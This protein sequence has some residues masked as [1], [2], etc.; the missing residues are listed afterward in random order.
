[1]KVENLRFRIIFGQKCETFLPDLASIAAVEKSNAILIS[2]LLVI[3]GFLLY[4]LR[5]FFF[6]SQGLSNFLLMWLVMDIFIFCPWYPVISFYCETQS[7][8]SDHAAAYPYKI[9]FLSFPFWRTCPVW[10]LFSWTKPLFSHLFSFCL[11][12]HS[13]GTQNYFHFR[14]YFWLPSILSCAISFS[15]SGILIMF[16]VCSILFYFRRYQ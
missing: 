13:F 3:S 8:G 1:M 12:V 5:F 7:F 9:I 2:L 16:Q 14:N 15:F 10:C 4:T 6:L 11:L